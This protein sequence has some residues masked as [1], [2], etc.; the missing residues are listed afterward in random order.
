MLP[1]HWS[2]CGLFLFCFA[3]V[4]T[5][6][7]SFNI[8]ITTK[9]G[10]EEMDKFTFKEGSGIYDDF[11]VNIYDELVFNTIKNEYEVGEI[12]NKTGVTSS[13]RVLDVGSGTGHHVG[14]IGGQGMKNVIGVDQSAAMVAAAKKNYPNYEFRVGNV[15]EG[16]IFDQG[17]FTHITCLYFTIYYMNNRRQFFENA[18]NWLAGGGFLV[19]HLVHRDEFDPILPPGN[20]LMIVSPQRYA[21]KRITTT[22]VVFDNFNYSSDFELAKDKNVA[23]FKEKFV[24]HTS[25]KVR[26]QEHIL[27]MATQKAILSEA[28]DAGFLLNGRIDLVHCSYEYQYL[29]ILMKPE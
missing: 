9:E 26:K 27:H 25:G 11:Y 18:F 28:A 1:K 20:P 12:V 10:F 17:S 7:I 8:P 22:K 2:A 14:L 15:E 23:K 5:I 4:A 16:M 19:L 29:F 6:M 21:K 3:I 13:S 24:D